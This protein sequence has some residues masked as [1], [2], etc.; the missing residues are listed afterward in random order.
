MMM[1]KPPA[2]IETLKHT[3]TV[4]GNGKGERRLE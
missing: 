1:A 2:L 3:L 4:K